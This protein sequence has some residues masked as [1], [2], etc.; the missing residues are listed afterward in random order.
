MTIGPFLAEICPKK[1]PETGEAWDE[2]GGGALIGDGA[3]F[4]EF[5]VCAFFICS[6]QCENIDE[7]GPLP[8]RSGAT[9]IDGVL[10]YTCVCPP[11]FHGAYNNN[12]LV[13][14]VCNHVKP[15]FHIYFSAQS[16]STCTYQGVLAMTS[17]T[18]WF[19]IREKGTNVL[20][21]MGKIGEILT[22]DRWTSL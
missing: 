5:T 6:L 18:Y 8:C 13:F 21:N 3:L 4:W 10:D 2:K 14:W 16:Y 7:C 12:P 11:Q 20:G 15:S 22:T 19:R 9:C 1:R 17:C